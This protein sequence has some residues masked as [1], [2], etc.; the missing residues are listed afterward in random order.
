MKNR[1]TV[2]VAFMLV[3]AMV[4]GVGYA[5]GT[6]SLTIKGTATYY[7]PDQTTVENMVKFTQA[8]AGDADVIA[9]VGDGKAATMEIVFDASDA[10]E[11][12]GKKQITKT[13]TYVI[14]YTPDTTAKV[15]TN[16]Q[17][18]DVAAVVP[19]TE[20]SGIDASKLSISTTG[21][22]ST[23]IL[24][25]TN[26]TATVTVTAILDCTDLASV[27]AANYAFTITFEYDFIAA[28][29]TT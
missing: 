23:T 25:K 20:T 16:V 11:V 10:V 14:T 2:I 7:N 1:R 17:F 29:P 4:I 8:T 12:E 15:E 9:G 22:S 6:G 5:V 26:N 21:I 13:A 28:Q 24:D 19:T 3:A 27:T 18:K